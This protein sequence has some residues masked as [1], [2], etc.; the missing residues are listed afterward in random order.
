M[1]RTVLWAVIAAAGV[2]WTTQA[3]AQQSVAG[4]FDR[5]VEI[6][7]G[8]SHRAHRLAAAHLLGEMR[9][10]LVASQFAGRL[11]EAVPQIDDPMV[12]FVVQRQSMRAGLDA[13]LKDR[14]DDAEFAREQGCLVDW[15]LLGPFE[16]S[17]MQGFYEP[18]APEAGEV[19]PYRGRTAQ[20]DWRG[21][22]SGHYLCSYQLGSRV[23]PSTSAVAYLATTIE[24][25]TPREAE[26][27]VGARSAYRVWVNGDPVGQREDEHGLGL[28]AEGWRINLDSGENEILVKL[29]SSGSGGLSWVARLVD[30]SGESLDG[31]SASGGVEASVVE[32]FNA[33]LEPDGGARAAIAEAVELGGDASTA[34]GAAILWSRLY[35]DDSSTPWRDV[36]D[37]LAEDSDALSDREM[38]WLAR[39]YEEHWRRQAVLDS[40]AERGDDLLVRWSRAEERG[41]TLSRMS[42]EEQR[43]ELQSLVEE[44]PRFLMARRSLA[45][46]FEEHEGAHRA[47]RVME[48][49]DDDQR[50]STPAWVSRTARL[51][52]DVGD[53]RRASELR[54]KAAEVHQ[55]SG[56]FGWNLLRESMAAGDVDDALMRAQTLRQRAPWSRRWGLQEAMIHRASDRLDEALMILD[57]L[58]EEA[59]GNASLR[60]RRAEYLLAA[61]DREAAIEAVE[62]AI[63]LRPQ[64]IRYQEFLDH[65]QPESSRFYEP[66]VVANL[67][68]L[69][70]ETEA[71]SQT[72]DFLV[73]QRIQQV[74]SNGLARRFEQRAYRVLRDEGV[75]GARQM[76]VSYRPGDERV[77]VLGVR[78][79]KADGTLSEDYDDWTRSQTRQGARQY[80]DRGYVTMRA[81]NVDVGDVVEFRYVV[82]QVANE[83]FRGDYFGDVRYVQR[84]RPV[85]LGRYAVIYPDDW[86]M[87]FRPPQNDYRRWEDKFP[88]GEPSSDARITAFELRDIPR[89]MTEDDQPGSTEI[90]DHIMVSNKET[91]D[92]IGAWWWELIAEQMVVDD[93]IRNTVTEVI[94]GL[95]GDDEKLEAIYEYVV[96]NTR[97]L[98]LGLGI[99]GWKPYRTSTVFRNRYGD[100]KDKAAL[101][102][103]MLEEA[104]IETQM[105]LVRTRRLGLVDD[106]PASMHVF[107]HAVAYVPSK[108]LYLDPTARFNGPY[109]LTQM[110][111]GAHALVV[112]DGGT[113]QWRRM[114][115]DDAEDNL[116]RETLKVDLR[117]DVPR[118]TGHIEAHGANAVRDR[119]QLE[120][121]DRRD[122]AFEDR[123]RRVFSGLTLQD[124]EYEDLDGLTVP[125]RIR[126]TA[127]APGVLRGSPGSHSIY[128]YVTSRELLR[129]YARQ[130]TRRQDLTFR[131]PFA[132]EARVHYQLAEAMAVEEIPESTH[133]ESPFGEMEISYQYDDGELI[134]DLRYAITQ[135][136]I[137]VE[138]YPEFRRF[139]AEMDQALNETIR[140][141]ESEV[142]R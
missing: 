41:Q 39:L 79:L 86:E 18:L 139:I 103:V 77:E 120:D 132:R 22:S 67:R 98:H 136:R 81:N 71:G 54:R 122:E 10:Y 57:G 108:D 61:G 72:Y 43:R 59:P 137:D 64:T 21:L 53:A 107:N 12:A 40:A 29:G 94:D 68:E 7:E 42:L 117:G 15:E 3:L 116:F 92:E 125:T 1:R 90:Y 44:N 2:M 97:Y 100:C 13:G 50:E 65:L 99:H 58:I 27:L 78:V 102:K 95:N 80:N 38:V 31:W 28:D 126:F 82:H 76:R 131:V 51:H 70:E 63:A 130:S 83:N 37:R 140:L 56:T 9:P 89:V 4:E 91:Y 110:D 88:G 134:V 16:N 75:S 49:W 109:E 85:A 119:R 118:M 11:D 114:P 129:D 113:T 111:Q 60:Q 25:E 101:L 104:G 62:E 141:V 96:R 30:E 52:G 87:F 55:L 121:P 47:L 33:E 123:L 23:H 142:S 106:Y 19:G 135:Q 5:L 112:E 24:V 93:A 105:V 115:V 133:L 20:I 46:W 124:A 69:A 127:E 36:A 138:D 17:S 66:W 14:G 26:L 73:D 35:S 84:T 48:Q 34:L 6:V 74:S 45:R 8:D 32:P 128:P